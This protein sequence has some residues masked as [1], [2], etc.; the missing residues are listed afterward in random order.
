MPLCPSNFAFSAASTVCA[1]PGLWKLPR[2]GN[3]GKQNAFSTVPSALGKLAKER[4]EFPTVTTALRLDPEQSQRQTLRRSL[5]LK[6]MRFRCTS[7]LNSRKAIVKMFSLFPCSL[8][9]LYG[10][11]C[12]VG[13]VECFH[14]AIY[15]SEHDEGAGITG[16]CR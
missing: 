2:Y 8:N 6:R 7:K 12:R 1:E 14:T 4:G 9:K 3:R 16:I 10:C 15:L 5:N 13:R 11:L